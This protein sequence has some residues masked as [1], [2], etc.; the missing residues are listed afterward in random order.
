[1]GCPVSIQIGNRMIEGR[2]ES[3]DETGALLLRTTHGHLERVTGGD[4]TLK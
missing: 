4:V 2:A 1:L 3:L